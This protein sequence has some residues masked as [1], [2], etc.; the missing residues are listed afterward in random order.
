MRTSLERHDGRAT[1]SSTSPPGTWGGRLAA[2]NA[3]STVAPPVLLSSTAPTQQH[4]RRLLLMPHHWRL[5]HD[6]HRPLPP[7]W[8]AGLASSARHRGVQIRRRCEPPV[9]QIYRTAGVCGSTGRW[10]R[11]VGAL[12]KGTGEKKKER[13]QRAR[14][15]RH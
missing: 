10:S 2:S 6:G 5:L 3:A 12:E 15:P 1:E 4:R 11:A 8:G 9:D 13:E 14:V 7:P